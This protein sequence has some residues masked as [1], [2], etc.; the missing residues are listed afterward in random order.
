V[1]KTFSFLL[2]LSW[3]QANDSFFNNIVSPKKFQFKENLNVSMLSS[4][5]TATPD[6]KKALTEGRGSAIILSL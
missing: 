6:K 2:F 5:R 4:H 3:I 1:H